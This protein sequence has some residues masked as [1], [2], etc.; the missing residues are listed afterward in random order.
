MPPSVLDQLLAELQQRQKHDTPTGTP[1]TP[2]Y[3]GPGGLFGVAGI[4]RDVFSTRLQPRGLASQLPAAGT[5]MMSPLFAY[6]TGFQDVSGSN[7]TGVCD[8]PQIAGSAKNCLQT[9][10]FG[11]Y[12]FM[13]RELELNRVG[14][15]VDRGEFLDLRIVNDP[16]FQAMGGVVDPSVPG[17]TNLNREV[18]MRFVELGVTFQNKMIRQVYSGN[19][20]NNTSGDGYR[21]FPGLDILIGTNKV[22]AL[23][24]QDCPSL[25]SLIHNFNFGRVDSNANTIINVLAYYMRNLRSKAE[26]QGMNPVQ[27]ALVMREGLFYELTAI[28]PCSYLTYRCTFRTT[29]G[30]LKEVVD[31][32]DAV[33]FRDAM[34][35]GQYLLID[36]MQYPVILDD[37][38]DEDTNTESASVTSGCF[39]S[40]IYVVPLTVMGGIAVTH[41]QYLDYQ[42]GAM[43]G[44]AD[45]RLA[46]S[47]FWTDGGRFLWHAKPPLNWCVQWLAKLE[48]RLILRTP[49]LAARIQNV[50][51][52][53]L[54]HEAES[55]P[56]DPYFVDGGVTSRT[57]RAL[58][59]DWNLQASV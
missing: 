2:Y 44:A 38:I 39:A 37:G 35:Q 52:C 17:N 23:T 40:D 15:Q 46:G 26:K 9:A 27:W 4:E 13:T 25:D 12:S 29:D 21:E 3:H 41:W 33:E 1:S 55:L 7:P 34:R 32:R 45:G 49:W 31:A 24:G 58:Y 56:T 57:A 30:T 59:S 14:Q 42:Q 28:W 54:I 18:L 36:G 51:Y 10:Q 20:A 11:R 8:D 53:P 19:P 48:P 5:N 6:I 47:Y 50:M 43:V 22:D 16:L